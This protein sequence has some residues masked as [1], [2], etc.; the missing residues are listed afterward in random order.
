M[1]YGSIICK[2]KNPNCNECIIKSKCI[3]YKKNHQNFIPI[4]VKTKSKK[5]KKYSRAYIFYNENNEILVRKRSS[6]GMLASMLE[7]PNDDW[8]FNK[9]KLL[10]DDIAFKL[11][12]KLKSKGLLEYSFSHFN[13]E[14]EVFYIE[15]KKYIFPNQKCIKKNNIKKS[16]M[17]TLMKKITQVAL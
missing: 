8:V 14:T 13:L 10:Y 6:K 9:N 3:S 15:V 11:K 4:K 17:P 16:G 7:V 12:D 1:D 2:P 5:V